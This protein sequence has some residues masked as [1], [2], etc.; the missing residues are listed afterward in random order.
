MD[1][2][3]WFGLE[4]ALATVTKDQGEGDA[5]P[6]ELQCMANITYR[7]MLTSYDAPLYFTKAVFH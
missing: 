4:L 5:V 7:V 6:L 3:L 1:W 2:P